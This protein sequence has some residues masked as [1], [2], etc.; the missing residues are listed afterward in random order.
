MKCDKALIERVAALAGLEL[1]DEEISFYETHMTRILD[2][3]DQLASL[4]PESGEN[5]QARA[6]PERK[7][8]V[9]PSLPAEDAV[10]SAPKTEGTSFVVPRILE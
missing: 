1:A 10:R 2:Y 8:E 4:E 7:D 3:V 5:R 9:K 6:T